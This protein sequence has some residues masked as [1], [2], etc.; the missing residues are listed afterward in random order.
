MPNTLRITL[1]AVDKA[2]AGCKIDMFRLMIKYW[3]M[4]HLNT[5]CA[6]KSYAEFKFTGHFLLLEWWLYELKSEHQILTPPHDCIDYK[7]TVAMSP[8]TFIV[9]AK[10]LWHF[11]FCNHCYKNIIHCLLLELTFCAIL[12]VIFLYITFLAAFPFLNV[13]TPGVLLQQWFCFLVIHE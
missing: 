1:Q 3:L 11:E 7:I 5:K 6:S 13:L 10:C 8:S 9:H 12:I 2:S 4:L